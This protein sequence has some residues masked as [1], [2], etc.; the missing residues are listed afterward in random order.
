[1]LGRILCLHDVAKAAQRPWLLA[2]TPEQLDSIIASERASGHRAGTLAEAS[3]DP[4]RF[5]LSFDDAHVSLLRLAAPQLSACKVPGAVFV[6]TDYVGMSDEVLS[7]DELRALRD[8]GWTIGAHTRTHPRMS[9]R[10]YDEDM[11][12]YRRRLHDEVARSRELLEEKLG[13]TV[14]DFAY[15]YGET[16][17]DARQAVEAAG[18]ERAY[19]VAETMK[20][21]GDP[22]AIP[23][24]DALARPHLDTPTPIS[25][26]IPACDRHEILTEVIARWSKQS[27]PSEA[28]EV[29]VVDDGSRESLRSC[30]EGAPANV[31]LVEHAGAMG[32]F[33]AGAA[34][35]RGAE[36]ARFEHL[37]FVDADVAV[38]ADFLWA[39]DWVHQRVDDAVLLGY[40]SGYNLHDIGYIHTLADLRRAERAEALAI[41]PDR[42]R[43]PTLRACFD[44][45][46]WLDEPWRLAYT[47]NLSLTKT[48]LRRIGGFA[49]EFSGWGLE[50][51][52]LGYRLHRAGARF[53]FS[54][55]AVGYHIVDPAEGPSRNPFRAPAP[56]RDLFETY[57]KNLAT[58][59]QLHRE[60]PAITRFV[61]QASADID[62]TCGKPDTVGVEMGGAC[63]LEC[64]FHRQLHHCQAGGRSTQELFDRLAYAIKVGARAL[65]LLGGEPADHPGFLQLV[66]AARDANLQV[67]SE[68]TALPFDAEGFAERARDAGLGRVV[69]EILAW[70]EAAYDTVTRSRGA[71]P[72]FLRGLERLREA[73]IA[74]HA[75]LVVSA[76]GVAALLGEIRARGLE[77][78]SVVVVPYGGVDGAALRAEA[79]R[80]LRDG[81]AQFPARL[82]EPAC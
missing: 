3:A 62:E 57:E 67:T 38:G 82:L 55:F 10:L 36:L 45:L 33:R 75:R 18:Y 17:P 5:A 63:S 80:V 64:S 78:E 32:T 50:D 41:I 22:L 12:A 47:G 26:V 59:A 39:L 66:S 19:T 49:P 46:D 23:R 79:E 31:R 27:Y 20:W 48:T 14:R 2:V 61:A 56:T 65:Y 4:A 51:I 6:A 21:T 53:V 34:R 9:W 8:A 69:V 25:V 44:N 42:S 15:P 77:L 81:D 16:T 72:R 71:F 58:L 52:D 54:R 37:A 29:I 43:E 68:T 24:L 40:L 74:V 7:W 73:G 13:I 11:A 28:F 76:P 70:D 1:V 35:Q 30:L 60:D